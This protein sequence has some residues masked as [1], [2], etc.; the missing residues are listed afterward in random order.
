MTSR[1]IL[2]I[3]FFIQHTFA[4]Q[5]RINGFVT[6]QN[7]DKKRVAGVQVNAATPA[8]SNLVVT[9]SDGS[10]T[11]IFQDM[12]PGQ[13]VKITAEKPGWVIVN[14][15]EMDMPIPYAGDG[16]SIK[17]I[18]CPIKKLEEIKK[19]YYK[20]T[21]KYINQEY[22]RKLAKVDRS[23]KG[24]EDSVKRIEDD[25]AV[26]RLQVKRIADEYSLTNRDD[27]IEVEKRAIA[28]F[29]AGNIRESIR[30]RDS[31]QSGKILKEMYKLRDSL[32]KSQKTTFKYSTEADHFAIEV[33]KKNIANS[34][35]LESEYDIH[36]QFDTSPGLLNNN[37]QPLLWIC[38]IKPE[39]Y[40]SR[41]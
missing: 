31:L 1:V 9:Q 22:A 30:I 12:L 8:R 7:S 24:W 32:N 18:I 6:E 23:K 36:D 38:F 29:E 39:S 41:K 28:F 14:K 37:T 17:I 15:T 16:T 33:D 35:I 21:D 19:K 20:I 10:F 5:A 3:T 11:L 26:L 27:L 25:V 13:F 40:L 4:Q 34:N 2:F